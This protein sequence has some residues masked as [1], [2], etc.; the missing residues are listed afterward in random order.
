M[1]D[2]QPC[3]TSPH[4][5]RDVHDIEMCLPEGPR[6][7]DA[8]STDGLLEATSQSA[9]E[10]TSKSPR[11]DNSPKE[12]A[13]GAAPAAAS[14][15][16]FDSKGLD[17]LW[18]RAS[19]LIALL[20]LQSTSS[21]VLK[22]FQLLVQL[23]PA[24]VFY[25]TM[26]VGAGGNAGAQSTILSIRKLAVNAASMRDGSLWAEVMRTEARS[27]VF[28]ALLLGLISLVRCVMFQTG[29]YECLAIGLSMLAI[30]FSSTIVG[31]AF[32]LLLHRLGVDPA[33]AGAA[34]QV[35]MDIMGVSATCIV[36]CWVLGVPFSGDASLVAIGD[37]HREILRHAVH[38]ATRTLATAHLA[39]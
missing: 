13:A 14:E 33:H 1:T 9:R 25:L 6:F 27:G 2:Y 20:M 35:T 37:S 5:G 24:V 15:E 16:D 29:G 28:L 39:K 32:P 22:R 10:G 30:V 4:G 34:I 8:K 26:L 31:A 36:S 11:E 38:N 12:P 17:C 21:F 19:W 7:A 23:H 3:N 18:H